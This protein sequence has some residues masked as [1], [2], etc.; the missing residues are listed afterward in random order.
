V[1]VLTA[2]FVV[3]W[4][5]GWWLILATDPTT[6]TTIVVGRE[7]LARD[8]LQAARMAGAALQLPTDHHLEETDT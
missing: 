5:D 7:R 8:A 4:S 6:S 2:R 1:A 3:R